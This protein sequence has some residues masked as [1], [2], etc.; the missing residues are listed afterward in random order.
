MTG[1]DIAISSSWT[2][3]GFE[4]HLLGAFAVL[5]AFTEYK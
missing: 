2:K 1:V 4:K 5:T 3:V